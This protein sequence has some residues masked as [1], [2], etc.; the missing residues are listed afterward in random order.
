[1]TNPR[2]HTPTGSTVPSNLATLVENVQEDL[3]LQPEE[4]ETTMR[5]SK[6]EDVVH[7]FTEEA[8]LIRRFLRLPHFET[9]AL[10]VL[11]NHAPTQ[12]VDVTEYT[13]GPITGVWGTVPVQAIKIQSACRSQS[14]H[15]HVVSAEGLVDL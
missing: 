1:M 5:W 3:D 10:R 4:K 15:C 9:E 12:R 13:S 2:T 7:V 8:G 14:S 11:P 6:T